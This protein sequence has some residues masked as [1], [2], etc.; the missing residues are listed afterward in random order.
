[1]I[2]TLLVNDPLAKPWLV[3][4]VALSSNLPLSIDIAQT[5]NGKCIAIMTLSES[6]ESLLA[7]LEAYG[8]TALWL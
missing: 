7:S 1:M 8:M 4:I 6:L 3:V 2:Q 5:G